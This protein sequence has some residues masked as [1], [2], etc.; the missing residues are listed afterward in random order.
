MRVFYEC[1][2]NIYEPEGK[3]LTCKIGRLPSCRDG[4]G[5]IL[6]YQLIDNGE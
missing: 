1:F 3:S 2:L 4:L 5:I 6:L